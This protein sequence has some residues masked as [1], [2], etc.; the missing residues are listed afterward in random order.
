MR[1]LKPQPGVSL[2]RTHP[3]SQGLALCWLLNEG[4]GDT[5]R[6]A[7]VGETAVGAATPTWGTGRCDFNGTDQAFVSDLAIDG[8][9]DFSVV[10]KVC[11]VWL[12]SECVAVGFGHP[13]Y[14]SRLS[15]GCLSTGQY[16]VLLREDDN[17]NVVNTY[18]N[19][20]VDDG[21][22]HQLV[23]IFN[24][25][26]NRFAGY[27]DEVC[28]VDSIPDGFGSIHFSRMAIGAQNYHDSLNSFWPA[29]IYHVY[30]YRR[31]LTAAEVAQLYRESYAMFRGALLSAAALATDNAQYLAGTLGA[32][33][34]CSATVGLVRRLAGACAAA[35]QAGAS[36]T[37]ADIM[38]LSG[39]IQAVSSLA[40]SV[41]S[42]AA[43]SHGGTAW[44]QD[45]LF[46]GMTSQ[47]FHLAT[48]L[49]RG[50]F[51]MR[52]S[53]CS[54]VYRGRTLD[55]VDFGAILCTA[56]PQA[57]QIVLPSYLT[58]EP[59]AT[60]CYVVRRFNGCGHQ[61]RTTAARV[62]IAIGPDGD[63][64]EP[65][66][67]G[68]FGLAARPAGK[69][70]VKLCWL[71]CPLHQQA[72]PHAFN[73][74]GDNG[75]GQVDLVTALGTVPYEGRRPYSFQTDPLLPGRY[76][77]IVRAQS[78]DGSEGQMMAAASCTIGASC[79]PAATIL[80]VETS[81]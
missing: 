4:V 76:T 65:A 39:V 57:G 71:Y 26:A 51:C 29:S 77:F 25:S 7:I 9:K 18:P 22:P 68:V 40:G 66:P 81:P 70:R 67:N 63:L 53:G 6:D 34:G 56:N 75:T 10:M 20:D 1:L 55:E 5:T 58:H 38:S 21:V 33:T 43:P 73:V 27:V 36:L 72:A 23:F 28:V 62:T 49:T 78:A 59:G 32:V 42:L 16:R 19:S 37:Q 44:W 35:S 54:A 74:Y 64:V 79:P 30:V 46:G 2:N 31:A 14:N 52:P 41:E 11:A 12:G 8:E 69:G 13:A 47:A 61:E 60:Y 15:I 48:V 3:L 17:T 24:P 45:A 50:W 80:A